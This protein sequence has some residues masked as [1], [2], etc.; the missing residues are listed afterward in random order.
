MKKKRALSILLA[1]SMT[2]VMA[3]CGSSS[4]GTS[5]TGA[6]ERAAADVEET[7]ETQE[8]A[9]GKTLTYWIDPTINSSAI[10]NFDDTYNW[11][12][13]QENLGIDI[14]WQ[15]PASGQ[16]S[17]QFNL[18]MTD[19]ELPDIIY[20]NWSNYPGGSADAAIADGKII[21]LNDYMEEYAPNL[22]AYLEAHPDIAREITTDEGNI[23]CFPFV[24]TR[25]PSDSETW[26]GVMGR[27]PMQESFEGL[28][29]RKDLLDKAGLDM[30][31]TVDDW[32]NVLR[33]FKD[34]G[35]EYPLSFA[36]D[37]DRSS[38]SLASAFDIPLLTFGL[39]KEG[40]IEY[41]AVG[42][43]YRDYLEFMNKLYSE[44]LLDPD[45]MVQD[46][47]TCQA[48][49]ANGQ[50]GAW[51]GRVPAELGSIEALVF[52]NDPDS[53]FDAVAI[54]NPV[55]EEGQELY[56]FQA[57]YPYR[58]EGAAI[59]T[60]CEDIE[61]AMRLL[62]YCWSEEG[63]LLMNW[64]IEGESYTMVDGW[65]KLTDA[66]I[67]KETG[68]VNSDLVPRYR[69]LNGPFAADHDNR[70]ATK[71]NYALEEGE[72]DQNL[73]ALDVWT[74]NGT[75]P[76]A[77]PAITRLSSESTEYST[78]YSEISTYAEEM[79]SKFIFGTESLDKY[80]SYVDTIY[81]MGLDTVL[82]IQEAA[83]ARYN[84]RTIK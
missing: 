22:S 41:G 11:Q 48:K 37:F 21:A 45:F 73:A 33:A 18:M 83:L 65:P 2:A 71:Q 78:K 12:A 40:K 64:G 19:N 7:G 81:G 54:H 46:R 70:I 60:S 15:H 5:G 34:M 27:E 66:L 28:I 31:V 62:D 24:Y 49:I 35:I 77:L 76:A 30:P 57:S 43:G 38:N 82:E 14:V 80:D 25:T 67:N 16:S 10:S 9:S 84:A 55:V 50:V 32:Y 1:V 13:V 56:Y 51:I 3:A 8:E 36:K 47:E 26:Q 61:T 44:G 69:M 39:N 68:G 17:E 42:E 20:Y 79:Y 53:D 72:T 29:I 63:D 58:N 75:Q 6:A 4:S 23:Y 74:E 52:E 59:T